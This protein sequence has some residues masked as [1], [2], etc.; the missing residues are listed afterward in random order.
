MGRDQKHRITCQNPR[1]DTILLDDVSDAV[2][3]ALRPVL[4]VDDEQEDVALQSVRN[5]L[6]CMRRD[7]A[8][9]F[10]QGVGNH[11]EKFMVKIGV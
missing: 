7:Q 4:E 9:T 10:M 11:T 1:L 8:M 2:P 6:G 3:R 5:V